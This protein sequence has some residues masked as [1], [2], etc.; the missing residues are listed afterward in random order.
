MYCLTYSQ[1]YLY[2]QYTYTLTI[3]YIVPKVVFCF[4]RYYMKM[5]KRNG[6]NVIL[7]GIFKVVLYLVFLNISCYIA[8]I[9]VTFWTVYTFR[10]AQSIMA[11]VAS[12]KCVNCA[13]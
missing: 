8:E 12:F 3:L 5:I 6:E 10:V 1:T 13:L 9:W 11:A 7:S 4:L 2:V